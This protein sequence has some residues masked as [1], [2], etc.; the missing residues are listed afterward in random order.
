MR[1]R[2]AKGEENCETSPVDIR[3]NI[4]V[5]SEREETKCDVNELHG[6]EERWTTPRNDGAEVKRICV[7]PRRKC[8]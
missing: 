4:T 8:G 1:R 6:S 5:V 2:E 7:K 3:A